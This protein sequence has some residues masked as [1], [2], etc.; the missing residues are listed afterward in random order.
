M[1]FVQLP[2]KPLD[3]SLSFGSIF[4]NRTSPQCKHN[5]VFLLACKTEF[6]TS[7]SLY[8]KENG[9][10]KAKNGKEDE[11]IPLEFG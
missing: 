7:A 10:Y 8:A 2:V 1:W 4:S 6:R 9:S 11:G 5:R 3:A